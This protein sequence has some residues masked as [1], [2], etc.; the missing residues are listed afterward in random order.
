MEE[1]WISLVH[2]EIARKSRILNDSKGGYTNFLAY[3][4]SYDAYMTTL[5]EY[6]SYYKI[7]LVGAEDV[8][9]LSSRKQKY[10]IDAELYPLISKLEKT[11]IPQTSTFHTY[12]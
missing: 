3:A 12:K 5:K 11:R 9:L 2:V 6:C 1:I 10:T 4:S 7:K 8:E